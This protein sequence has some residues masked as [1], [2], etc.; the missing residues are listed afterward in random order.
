M[1]FERVCVLCSFELE[2]YTVPQQ[3]AYIKNQLT[4]LLF[5][6]ANPVGFQ[7]LSETPVFDRYIDLGEDLNHH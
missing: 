1:L 7:G 5:S 3:P 2:K 6:H 4:G